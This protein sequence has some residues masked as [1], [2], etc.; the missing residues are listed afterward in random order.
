[1]RYVGYVRVSTTGQ[2][3]SGLGLEAQ[4]EALQRLV[5]DRQGEL[6]EVFE[7]TESGKSSD[8]PRLKDA[9]RACRRLKATLVVAKLDRLARNVSFIANLLESKVEFI[10]ADNPHANNLTIHILAALAEHERHLISVRTKEAL[11]RVK[12][13]K[14]KTLGNPKIRMAQPLAVRAAVAKAD[15]FAER[16]GPVLRTLDPNEALSASRLAA[17]MNAQG[18][19]TA[20][21]GR[22][23]AKTT[24][25]L[26]KRI[27]KRASERKASSHDVSRK[28]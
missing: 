22:W 18:I 15:T 26:K 16:L 10:A 17:L 11:A 19:P 9:L 13:K 27:K 21:G 2:A 1:M 12:A 5:R 24:I 23:S 20:R 14:L 28:V 6:L 4:R 25:A 3:R 7:E 8:R